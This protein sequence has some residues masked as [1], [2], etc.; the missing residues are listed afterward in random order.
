MKLLCFGQILCRHWKIATILFVTCVLIS[1]FKIEF[2][3]SVP[4]V[5]TL[6][7]EENNKSEFAKVI[8]YLGPTAT[9]RLTEST[10]LTVEQ[11]ERVPLLITS[12]GGS[13]T[14]FLANTFKKAGIKILHEAVGEHGTVGW[15]QLFNLNQLRVWERL[16][17]LNKTFSIQNSLNMVK[18]MCRTGGIWVTTNGG[19]YKKPCQKGDEL[20]FE[21]YFPNSQQ[22]PVYYDKVF[23]QV[24]DPLKTI[25]SFS[26]YCGH[27]QLWKMAC[28]V[29]PGLIPYWTADRQR[30]TRYEHNFRT[31]TKF[32]MYHWLSWNEKI[33][34]HADW[35]YRIENT[36]SYSI[37]KRAYSNHA[38]ILE[39]CN[40]MKGSTEVV[41]RNSKQFAGRVELKPL[42]LYRLDCKLAR[43]V[44]VAAVS[45]GYHEY[46]DKILDC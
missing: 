25:S 14:T 5:L 19:K 42:D 44:F 20:Y 10:E 43:S 40:F 22:H 15:W 37:C 33:A 35:T 2:L 8:N 9:T 21:P 41:R 27:S 30:S 6:P 39:K 18:K 23:H 17:K 13:G 32:M 31:C 46:M 16:I 36:S 29:T 7:P 4:T 12:M 3:R 28:S 26:K 38:S 45:Y 1:L 11:R 24:R 34:L